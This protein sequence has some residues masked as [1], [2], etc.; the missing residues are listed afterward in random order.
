MNRRKL[1]AQIANSVEMRLVRLI[2]IFG[3]ELLTMCAVGFA[4]MHRGI[5]SRNAEN[6]IINHRR[7]CAIDRLKSSRGD[8][9]AVDLL[10]NSFLV[11]PQ[12]F[13]F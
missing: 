8:L 11:V 1:I 5:A 7:S 10:E 12:H 4:Q 9:I 3:R 2:H 6:E 13:A